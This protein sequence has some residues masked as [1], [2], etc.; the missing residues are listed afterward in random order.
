MVPV[1]TV[2]RQIV[3]AGP[4]LEVRSGSLQEHTEF[5]G[6]LLTPVN[7]DVESREQGLIRKHVGAEGLF[8]DSWS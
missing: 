2:L 1:L 8:L 4:W 7:D 6:P 3:V 5:W